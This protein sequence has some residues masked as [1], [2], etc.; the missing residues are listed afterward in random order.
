MI[1]V[2]SPHTNTYHHFSKWKNSRVVFRLR[3]PTALVL[4]FYQFSISLTL[5]VCAIHVTYA[6][7]SKPTLYRCLNIK[8]LLARHSRNIWS[9]SGCNGTQTTSYLAWKQTLNHL[10]KLAKWLNW[11]LICNV[12]LTV[13]SY[14]V[15]R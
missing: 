3:S 7:Q 13:L 4:K 15:T 12:N 1:T 8:E 5:P 11:V 9:L 6:F 2:S 14:H 10:T